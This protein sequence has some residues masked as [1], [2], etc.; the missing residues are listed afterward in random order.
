MRQLVTIFL[1]L[2]SVFSTARA[3]VIYWQENGVP[4]CTEKGLQRRPALI[5]DRNGGA[6]ITWE[7]FRRGS[8]SDIYAQRIDR[9]GNTL[10]KENGI[11]VC[12]E[13]GNQ[14][15][16]GIIPGEKGGAIIV[17][18]DRRGS[19]YDVYAQRL[20]PDGSLA[21]T[22]ASGK[23]VCVMAEDQ[24]LAS[25]VPD[26]HGGVIVFWQDRRNGPSD[27]YAQRLDR[28]GNILWAENG[29]PVSTS[30]GKQLYP[31]ATRDGYGGAFVVWTDKRS[32]DDIYAQRVNADGTIA[33]DTT[34]V[35]IVTFPGRQ[36]LPRV[37]TI[38]TD[39]L[40]VIYLDY[41]SG[42]GTDLVAHIVDGAGKLL[43]GKYG[44]KLAQSE[45]SQAGLTLASAPNGSVIA[46]WTDYKGGSTTGDIYVRTIDS[47]GVVNQIPVDGTSI[48]AGAPDA[49]ENPSMVGDGFNGGFVTWQDRRSGNDFDLYM[50]RFNN[51]G[52]MWKNQ[53]VLL[54]SESRNQ[55]APRVIESEKG[56]AIIAWYD[57][58]VMDGV[59]DIYAQ[60]VGYTPWLEAPESFQMDD[61]WLGKSSRRI[62]TLKNSGGDTLRIFNLNFAGGNTRDFSIITN[63]SYPILL[64]MG[65]KLDVELEFSPTRG[66]ARST[67]IRLNTNA[68]GSPH[69]IP[70]TGIG[71]EPKIE[72]TR[73]F[74]SFGLLRIGRYKDSTLSGWIRSSGTGTLRLDSAWIDGD[75]PEY[76]SI[77]SPPFPVSLAPDSALRLTVRFTPGSRGLKRASLFIRHNAGTEPAEI[78][79]AGS[80]DFARLVYAPVSINYG[81]I[82]LN[83]DPGKEITMTASGSMGLSIYSISLV[84]ADTVDFRLVGVRS[85]ELENGQT[86]RV[87]VHYNP[88]RLGAS[89]AA[90]R[91]ETDDPNS[92]AEIPLRGEGDIVNS[93]EKQN[94][95]S[96]FDVS[97]FPNP[98]SATT[99]SVTI[100]VSVPAR[101]KA[102]LVLRDLLGRAISRSPKRLFDGGKHTIIIPSSSLNP[103][104]Y[105]AELSFERHRIVKRFTVV[106]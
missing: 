23:P 97:V 16:A 1:V 9:D 77:L 40:I 87:W 30:A 73:N 96:S 56:T 51:R 84:G 70:L 26:D 44:K 58:R 72:I 101:K 98:A 20:A 106:P 63:L 78:K 99:G 34:G 11:A 74:C 67:K 43:L 7:D 75:Y 27:I 46:G 50:R 80:G 21:W 19:S 81:K 55:L 47:T 57:G 41:G 66:G 22:P 6:F 3:Q 29:I 8:R 10:W 15:L 45:E 92:P 76:Y 38:G 62:Y 32:E 14:Y 71:I 35:P 52:A 31:Q 2:G 48:T 64:S 95:P 65:E 53:G 61:T 59:A 49:Q 13:A 25:I 37:A 24:Y 28:E 17:W 102:R 60:R 54:T 18:W 104:I 86:H 83:W 93:T 94:T 36:V 89:I 90:L 79:L 12:E 105:F 4:V 100:S 5:S 68:P 88:K 85:Y 69:F 39:R 42:S 33:W 82:P 91:I 103:G